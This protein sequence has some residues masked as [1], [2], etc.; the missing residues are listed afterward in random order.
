LGGPLTSTGMVHGLF[1]LTRLPLRTSAFLLMAPFPLM[2]LS[3]ATGSLFGT[4]APTLIS[5][6]QGAGRAKEARLHLS[7]T[8]A[9]SILAAAVIA[10]LIF[11]FMSAVLRL[12]DVTA[13]RVLFARLWRHRRFSPSAGNP[14]GHRRGYIGSA[15]HVGL[16][17]GAC[18][19]SGGDGSGAG[20][21]AYA[22]PR[23]PPRR[24]KFTWDHEEGHK[25]AHRFGRKN[26]HHRRPCGIVDRHPAGGL[27]RGQNRASGCLAMSWVLDGW[28]RQPSAWA[29]ADG[30]ILPRVPLPRSSQ[31][32]DIGFRRS[33]DGLEETGKTNRN[34]MSF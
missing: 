16:F 27:R 14:R 32:Q 17:C 30:D 5:I 8:F 6:S 31:E 21:S 19:H 22:A 3:A 11:L 10:L 25:T 2:L 13:A 1:C 24:E 18:R 12:L 7:Q 20:R 4:G 33:A 15:L 26:G 9:V 34:G 29:C 23:I 28:H